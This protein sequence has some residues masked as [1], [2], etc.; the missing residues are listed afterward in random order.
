MKAKRR[1]TRTAAPDW[2]Q[3]QLERRHALDTSPRGLIYVERPK[4]RCPHCRSE[5]SKVN[6]KRPQGDGCDFIYRVCRGCGARFIEV[7][8]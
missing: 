6:G 3:R 4:L 1:D 8:E 7:A 5:R 2:L